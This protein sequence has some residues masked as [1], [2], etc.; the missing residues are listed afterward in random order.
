MPAFPK[1]ERLCHYHLI[2]R[3]FA[4]GNSFTMYPYRVIWLTVDDLPSRAQV[5]FSFSR[6][7]IRRAADRNR[8]RRL[9]KEAYRLNKERLLGTLDRTNKNCI[10]A[11]IYLDKNIPAWSVVLEKM[12]QLLDRLNEVYEKDPDR[13]VRGT[14]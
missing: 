2:R 3:L 11:I 14:D 8:I 9:G 10:F 4:Q 7:N 1:N 12:N 6:K 5:L 13:T